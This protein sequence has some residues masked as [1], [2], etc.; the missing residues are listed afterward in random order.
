MIR[1]RE[2]IAL[3]FSLWYFFLPSLK[4]T[5]FPS[6]VWAIWSHLLDNS[7]P[8]TKTALLLPWKRAFCMAGS[9]LYP[10][11]FDLPGIH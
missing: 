9:G 2:A 8:V 7:H 4:V 11:A 6:A 5:S 10:H 3:F 1:D